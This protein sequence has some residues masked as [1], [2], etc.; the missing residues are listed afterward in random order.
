M[1]TRIFLHQPFFFKDEIK[2]LNNCI[3][4]KWVSTGGSYVSKLEKEISKFTKAKYSIALNSG[5][6]ALDLSLK[7]FDVKRNDEVI[8]PSITFVSPINCVLYQNASPIFMD[9]DDNFNIDVKK[10][11]DFIKNETSFNGKNT[12]NKKTKKIIKALIIVHVFGNVAD[13]SKLINICKKNKIYI[14]ED[15][16]ESLGSFSNKKIHTGLMGDI[17]CLSFN[18]NK[19]ITT[20]A[21]GMILTNKK[22][23]AL[24]AKYLSTQAK[25]DSF[26]FL[27]NNVGYNSRLNNVNAAIGCGQLKYIKHI[28]LKKKKI[29]NQY[30]KRISKLNNFQLISTKNSNNENHWLNVILF[31]KNVDREKLISIFKKN[32]V[33]IRPVWFPNHLQNKMKKFQKYKISKIGKIINNALCLPSGYSINEK[34]VKKITQILK[35]FE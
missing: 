27:H 23:I 26:Y 29:H 4:T 2:F 1:E 32:K 24:R 14:I 15:A 21:G 11:L 16:S 30:K 17:G 7:L 19:I 18:A 10:T 33:E 12:I 9:C 8:V 3:K 22:N 35:N 5:T 20:G 6:A 28:L 13:F 31:S 34:K 25:D